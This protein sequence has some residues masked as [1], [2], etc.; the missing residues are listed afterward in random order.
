MVDPAEDADFIRDHEL[1]SLALGLVDD[2]EGER[3]AITPIHA[4]MHDRKVAITDD[5][6]DLV[7]GDDF[8]R[9]EDGQGSCRHDWNRNSASQ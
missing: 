1:S 7:L 9:E 8:F 5:L 6:T 4:L 2:L 3:G